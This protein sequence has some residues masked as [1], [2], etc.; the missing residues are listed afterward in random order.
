MKHRTI[1]AVLAGVSV[2]IWLLVLII[3][4]IAAASMASAYYY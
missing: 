2:F 3:A 4:A 1:A